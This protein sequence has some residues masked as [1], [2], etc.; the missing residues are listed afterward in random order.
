MIAL[1]G[2]KRGKAAGPDGI[3][4]DFFITGKETLIRYLHPLFNKI[5]E[6]G[7]YPESWTTKAIIFP[8]HKKG[9]SRCVD[10]YRGISLLNVIS[11]LY[12]IVINNRLL[13]FC[14]EN[15]CIP[16]SQAGFRKNYNTVDKIFTLKSL[17]QKYLTKK[18]GRFYTLFVD[19]S[20]AYDCIDR[21]K[22]N[23]FCYHLRQICM[24]K[25]LIH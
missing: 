18:G 24:V 2:L 10:N 15:H 11:K 19:F 16:E 7:E 6:T 3:S 23:C 1:K 25:C 21:K 5:F 14:E 4:T 22:N 8:L 12:S 9:N 20:K 13:K 17:V